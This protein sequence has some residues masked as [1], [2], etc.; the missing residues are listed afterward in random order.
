MFF[1]A[2]YISHGKINGENSDESDVVLL[3][4]GAEVQVAVVDSLSCA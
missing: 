1:F 2:S 4:I 3:C